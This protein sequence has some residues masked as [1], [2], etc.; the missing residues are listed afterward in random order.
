MKRALG[1]ALG[2]AICLAVVGGAV[3]AFRNVPNEKTHF[4]PV[5]P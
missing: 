4:D 1:Y 3:A 2:I 5:L